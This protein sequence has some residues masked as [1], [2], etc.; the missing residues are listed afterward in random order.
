MIDFK[1][2]KR[3]EF[4]GS[5]KASDTD[6][7]VISWNQYSP[8]LLA[9]GCDDGSI[10]V[11]DIRFLAKARTVAEIQ[12]HTSPITSIEFQPFEDSVVTTSCRDNRITIWDFSVEADVKKG[13]SNDIPEQLMFIH[14]GVHDPTEIKYLFSRFCLFLRHHPTLP[15]VLVSTAENGF[16]IFKPNY[17]EIEDEY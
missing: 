15:D 10:K 16:N 5:I 12:W 3:T 4:I 13:K 17:E 2:G 7:N 14:Q 9:C 6:V 11:W 1:N 8:N